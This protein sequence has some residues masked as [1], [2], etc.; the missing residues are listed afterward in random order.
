MN[1]KA[2]IIIIE[3]E[4]N[5]CNFIETVLTPQNYHVVCA[6]TGADGLKQI[7]THKPDVVL[8]D[9]G[10]PDMDGLEI[11]EEVR[12]YSSVPII[13]ISAR[14]LERSKVA[15]LDMGA[16]DY[17]TKPFG[18]AELLARI[19][20]ALRHS[21]KTANENTRYEVG[22]L[23]IDFER[24]LVKVKDQDVHLTQIEYKLVSLLAQ[25]AGRVLTYE[26]IISKIWGP[27]ADSDNQILRVNM[28]HIRRKL[29]ENPAEP[30]YIFTEIGVGYRMREE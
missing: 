9:L 25:N 6:Y 14:T 26:T 1:A 13:V 15:A 27:Y 16:D 3:D 8:L 12:T 10:L 17:L 7:N 20:T 5:I 19:R 29:E 30:Q 4:K 24:R 28:A 23:M 11:I 18:T 2:S 21:Q 22:D